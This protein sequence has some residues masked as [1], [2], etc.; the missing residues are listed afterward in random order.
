MTR[1]TASTPRVDFKIGERS[2]VLL[3]Y[4]NKFAK[5]R[6]YGYSFG[7]GLELPKLLSKTLLIEVMVSPDISDVY[8]EPF[9]VKNRSFQ[10]SVGIMF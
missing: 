10:T 7:A 5:K 8:V 4:Y 2:N 9:D 6:L 3:V 1:P